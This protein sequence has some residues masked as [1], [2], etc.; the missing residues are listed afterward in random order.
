MKHL[1]FKARITLLCTLLAAAVALLALTVVIFNETRTVNAYYR[2]TLEATIELAQDDV[3]MKDGEL[4]IDRNLDDLPNVHV[5]LYSADGD[6]IY[7]R[8]RFS[9]P[10]EQGGMREVRGVKNMRWMVQDSLLEF[11]EGGSVWLRCYISSDAVGSMR[12]IQPKLLLVLLPVLILL[13][14]LG[15]WCIARRSVRP[16]AQIIRTA[17]GIAEGSDLKKR[18]GL[19]GVRDEIYQTARVFDDMLERLDGAFERERRFTSDASHELRTPVT[20]IML[21]SEAAMADDVSEGERMNALREINGKSRHMSL[22][23]QRLLALARLD[24]RRA[25]EDVQPV[26]MAELGAVVCDS[27]EERA[28]ARGMQIS[29]E[30]SA[31]AIVRGDQTMLTQ[32]ALNLAENAVNYGCENGKIRIEVSCAGGECRFSV[33]DDGPGIEPEAMRHLFE[34]FYQADASRHGGGFGLGLPLVKRIAEL[35]GGR[36]EVES[37]PGRGSCFAMVLPLMNREVDDE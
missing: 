27:M 2:N 17:E 16:I 34:R 6:L 23:I 14:A 7:G 35:H 32:A 25:P 4:K 29:A 26:D 36:V 22:L 15:G 11:P 18:I 3:I 12:G 20:G 30:G 8:Q 5:A 13:A 10:F 28:Q 37:A 19:T 33:T 21:Q 24:A 31:G 9:L 1:T